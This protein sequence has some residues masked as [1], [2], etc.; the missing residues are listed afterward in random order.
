MKLIKNLTKTVKGKTGNNI[1]YYQIISESNQNTTNIKKEKFDIK[2]SDIKKLVADL[3]SK[4]IR[5]LINGL[6]KKSW[7]NI[8]NMNGDM[9]YQDN[10]EYLDGKVNDTKSFSTF[11]QL[12]ILIWE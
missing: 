2:L 10:D 11:S 12:T 3:K 4:N 1:K 9:T 7:T 5:F 6:N 8:T